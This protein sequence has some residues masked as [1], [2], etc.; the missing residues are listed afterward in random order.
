MQLAFWLVPCAGEA[1]GTRKPVRWLEAHAD[2][3]WGGRAVDRE[4]RWEVFGEGR[5]TW[6]VVVSR[7][8]AVRSVAD[9]MSSRPL[10]QFLKASMRVE[11]PLMIWSEMNF[12]GESAPME[13]CTGSVKASRSFFFIVS[14]LRSNCVVSALILTLISFLGIVV[15]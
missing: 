2:E 6:R 15:A 10:N 9:E 4:E 5:E 13:N 8:F 7:S 1:A 11:M 12:H 14:M 3:C